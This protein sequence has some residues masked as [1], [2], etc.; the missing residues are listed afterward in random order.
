MNQRGDNQ[1]MSK[2]NFL[3][4]YVKDT[5]HALQISPDPISKIMH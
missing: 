5:E 1:G 2:A 3:H 4:S